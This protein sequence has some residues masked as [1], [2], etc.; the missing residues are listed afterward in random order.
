MQ[1]KPL[2]SMIGSGLLGGDQTS[3]E[4]KNQISFIERKILSMKQEIHIF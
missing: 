1:I 2:K 4:S 3:E